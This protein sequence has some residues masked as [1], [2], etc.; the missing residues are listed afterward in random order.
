MSGAGTAPWP[1]IGREPEERTG[2]EREREEQS[3]EKKF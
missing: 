2:G 1:P 3:P